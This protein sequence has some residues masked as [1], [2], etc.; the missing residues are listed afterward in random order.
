M[1][2]LPKKKTLDVERGLFLISYQSAESEN[3]PPRV[4]VTV[5]PGGEG[6]VDFIT[7]PDAD[8]PILWSPGACMIARVHRKTQL[9]VVVS[10][11][12]IG[13][14]TGAIVKVSAVSHDPGGMKFRQ[15]IGGPNLS[16]FRLIGHVA[17]IGDVTVGPNDWIAGPMTPS[18]IEG[19]AIEWPGGPGNGFVRY[20]ATI[21][22][23]NRTTT[24]LVDI[25]GFVGTR[26]RALPIVGVIFELSDAAAQSM[27]IEVDAIFLGSPQMH[28]VGPRT[29]LAG[30]TGREPL[31]GLKLRLKMT[32][33]SGKVAASG[34]P[35]PQRTQ[36]SQ[37][38]GVGDRMT[39]SDHAKMAAP[40]SS[41][42]RVGVEQ[43]V[44]ATRNVHLR[45]DKK[46]ERVRVFRSKRD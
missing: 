7:A 3:A 27:Q 11:D 15:S 13:G 8:G 10:Q 24:P 20:A 43:A 19:F 41:D 40:S 28:A 5:G 34:R 25:G 12:A 45:S 9:L 44:G 37:A 1:D 23:P 2:L 46:M 29:I 30:P 32:N 33:V 35:N 39:L 17:G 4:T 31:V 26:G 36:M 42:D 38:P 22:D 6:D 16:S 18:R 21:G 14:S